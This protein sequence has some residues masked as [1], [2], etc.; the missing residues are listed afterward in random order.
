MK[1]T[2]EF[3]I[4]EAGIGNLRLQLDFGSGKYY[5]TCAPFF[6]RAPIPGNP[7]NRKQ[8]ALEMVR[9]CLR[10]HLNKLEE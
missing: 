10:D 2:R 7:D 5:A 4:D 9:M 6:I 1:W 3:G 8:T